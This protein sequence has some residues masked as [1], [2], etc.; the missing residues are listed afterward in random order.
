MD[1]KR[2]HESS[3]EQAETGKA[4]AS[5]KHNTTDFKRGRAEP[6]PML[7][8]AND[9]SCD[10]IDRDYW[11]ASWEQL[12]PA[13][14]NPQQLDFPTA[15][16]STA[17]WEWV[18]R[19]APDHLLWLVK[20]FVF[21]GELLQILDNSVVDQWKTESRRDCV[22]DALQRYNNPPMD[23]QTKLWVQRW[24]EHG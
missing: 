8:L 15:N 6:M 3:P 14:P 5:H 1:R 4:D 23:Q 22:E 21:P 7:M 2:G 17:E 9:E 13:W 24:L 16:S 20:R 18:A 10:R 11:A 19:L 12:E